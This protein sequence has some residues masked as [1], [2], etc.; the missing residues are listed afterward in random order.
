MTGK[1]VRRTISAKGIRSRFRITRSKKSNQPVNSQ[2]ATLLRRR[3][4]E[5]HYSQ[6]QGLP[7]ELELVEEFKVS[8]HTLRAALQ[9]LVV[10][11]L[12]ER[13]RGSGTTV[14]HRNFLAGTW[15]VNALDLL[16]GDFYET[17]VLFAGRIPATENSDVAKL[18][19]ISL[20]EDLFKVVRLLKSRSGPYA[21]STIFSR[22][23]YGESVPR[24]LL[25]KRIFVSLIEEYCGISA[26]RVRQTIAAAGC[27]EVVAKELDV[28]PEH[29]MLRLQRQYLTRSGDLITHTELYCLSERY[30]PVA[31]FLRQ[32]EPMKKAAQKKGGK[33]RS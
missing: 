11:G 19:G 26:G 25:S 7:P 10:D 30:T 17:K 13:R 22:P 15:V 21:Y 33:I 2:I 1:S 8:R 20:D 31:I 9:K 23:E 12:I 5:G 28:A 4:V 29:P 24:K 16:V 32:N 27:P 6:E 18:F 3:I 14:V